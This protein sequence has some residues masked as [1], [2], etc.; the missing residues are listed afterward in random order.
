MDRVPDFVSDRCYFVPL[1]PMCSIAVLR[2]SEDEAN[3]VHHE[4]FWGAG[5][6]IF[7]VAVMSCTNAAAC[8]HRI[9]PVPRDRVADAT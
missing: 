1:Q 6:E 4:C 5:D 9:S 2:L 8:Y 3:L 7:H